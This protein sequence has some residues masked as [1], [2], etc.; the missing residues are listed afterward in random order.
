VK[1]RFPSSVRGAWRTLKRD[2]VMIG[3]PA[4]GLLLI[5]VLTAIGIRDIA[6]ATTWS[7]GADHVARG[8]GLIGGLEF[9]AFLVGVPLRAMMIAAGARALGREAGGLTRTGS[10][11]VVAL[12][13]GSLRVAITVV[14]GAPAI[15]LVIFLAGHGWI[16]LAVAGLALAILGIGVLRFGVR[17]L[18]GYAPILAVADRAGPVEALREGM[19]GPD[20]LGVTMALLIGDG[21]TVLGSLCCGAGALP[22]Y[23]IADLAILHRFHNELPDPPPDEPVV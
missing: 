12:A 6:M 22:G 9:A 17:A 3:L 15:L 1:E 11:L 23:P 16:G 4:A 5:D 19:P 7:A 20:L 21:A 2:P 13:I 18:F 10:L 8:L 14:L